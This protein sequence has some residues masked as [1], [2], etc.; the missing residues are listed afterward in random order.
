MNET[1]K[2]SWFV[3]WLVTFLA[4]CAAFSLWLEFAIRYPSPSECA[5]GTYQGRP[6]EYCG[7]SLKV[8]PLE[9][10]VPTPIGPELRRQP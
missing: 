3:S 8:R 9:T 2:S 6:Y 4:F 10:P 5:S 1:K 7:R